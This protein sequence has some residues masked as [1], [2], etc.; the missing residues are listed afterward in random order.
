MMKARR[1]KAVFKKQM[2]NTPH[3]IGILIQFSIHPVLML[4]IVLS[5]NQLG[6][7]GKMRVAMSLSTLFVGA[8]PMLVINN[9]IREDRVTSTLRML[10]MSTVKPIEYFIGINAWVLLLSLIDAFIFG[11]LGGFSGLSLITF[12][13]G[14]MFG[15]LTTLMLGSVFSI[16][17]RGSSQIVLGFINII[18][19]INGTFPIFASGNKSNLNITKYWYTQQVMDILGDLSANFYGNLYY[20]FIIIGANLLLFYILFII[21]Y[22]KNK[23]IS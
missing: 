21:S 23:M 2:M 17:I 7:T 3:N 14:L 8:T 4:I 19:I 15:V 10:I 11:I 1:I 18:S 16:A 9:T 22:K 6:D 5:S 13:S 20:R 12:V